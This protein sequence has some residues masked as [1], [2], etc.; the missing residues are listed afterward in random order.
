MRLAVSC[1]DLRKDYVL[2]GETVH[3]LRGVSFDVPE[4]DYFFVW[5]GVNETGLQAGRS[6]WVDIVAGDGALRLKPDQADDAKARIT[7]CRLWPAE[8]KRVRSIG[9]FFRPRFTQP[10]APARARPE[11]RS[12]PI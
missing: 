3:A 2:G 6:V 5:A 11:R 4:G 7:A 9:R 1:V 12:S 8:D 10:T